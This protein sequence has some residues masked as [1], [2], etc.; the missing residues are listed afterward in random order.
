MLRV[1]QL[2]SDPRCPRSGD[3][4]AQVGRRNRSGNAPNGHFDGTRPPIATSTS[5]TWR[6]YRFTRRAPRLAGGVVDRARQLTRKRQVSAAGL[7]QGHG[8]S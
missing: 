2:V 8:L 4:Y 7:P 5:S 3:R 6:I 1:R